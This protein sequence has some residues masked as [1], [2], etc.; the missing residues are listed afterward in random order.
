MGLPSEIERLVGDAR[1]DASASLSC[2]LDGPIGE[3]HLVLAEGRLIL[4]T[5]DSLIGTPTRH[6]LDRAN[7]PR[8]EKGDF[9]DTLHIELPDGASHALNVSSFERD[10][11]TKLLAACAEP[12]E[13]RPQ[14]ADPPAPAVI[15]EPQHEPLRAP[16]PPTAESAPSAEPDKRPEAAPTEEDEQ[17]GKAVSVYHCSETGCSSCLAQVLLFFGTPVGMWFAHVQAMATVGA[18][19][20]SAMYIITKV[21]AVIAGFYLGFKLLTL[22]TNLLQQANW[23]GRVEVKG[24]VARIRGPRGK[25]ELVVDGA[26]PFRVSCGIMSPIAGQTG[27]TGQGVSG[28]FKYFLTVEQNGQ[29]ATLRSSELKDTQ[30]VEIG[31]YPC[32]P[33]P[34]EPKFQ[35]LQLSAKDL[36]FVARRLRALPDARR[37]SGRPY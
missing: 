33:L 8:V 34:S 1:V 37:I 26:R 12:V 30:P 2:G 27:A 14:K 31:G 20:D 21:L 35:S 13:S 23:E 17:A 9:S 18:A 11:V 5:R 7:P 6:E 19:S 32:D 16:G 15:P 29:R 36:R 3:T 25:W 24:Q 4:F 10:A 28:N 22:L